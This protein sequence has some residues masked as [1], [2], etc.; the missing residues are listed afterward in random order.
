MS[1]EPAQSEPGST[2]EPKNLRERRQ[3]FVPLARQ[4]A[5]TICG[6]VEPFVS[7][8]RT[9]TK[10]V[11][12]TAQQ[13]DVLVVVVGSHEDPSV[14]DDV[15]A[16]ALAWQRDRDL[17]LVVPAGHEPATLSRLAWID[18]CVRV[19]AYGP[20]L[21]PRPAIILSRQETLD[22]AR[23]LHRDDE[24]NHALGDAET[25][26]S[27]LLDWVRRQPLKEEARANYIA[28]KCD[29]VQV[30][31]ASVRAYH[32]D[33]VVGVDYTGRLPPGTQPAL[34]R[35][36]SAKT[37]LRPE[38]IAE[39]QRRISAAVERRQDPSDVSY[40]EHRLQANL[41]G[42][43]LRDA[44]GLVD[45]QA[46]Y[47]VW[48]SGAHS[49]FIDFLGIDGDGG[50][51]LV[52]TKVNPDDVSVML[53]ALDYAVW[54][55][56]NEEAIRETKGWPRSN[57]EEGITV[58]L[59]CA[60]V[61]KVRP[62]GTVGPSRHAIGRYLAN[63]L[64]VLSKQIKC[65]IWLVSDPLGKPPA[66]R[67][68]WRTPPP[69]NKL[70]GK[71]VQLRRWLPEVNATL[72]K[73]RGQVFASEEDAA[74]PLALARFRSVIERGMQHRWLLS[75]RS[76]QALALNLFA[77]LG[78]DGISII[79]ERFGYL[80]AATEP[81]EFEYS[82]PADRLGERRPD[83]KHQTQVDVLLRGT[84]RRGERLAVLV[85]VKFT[86]E[87]GCCSAYDSKDNDARSNCR[88]AGLYGAEPESCFQLRNHGQGRR[89]YNAFLADQPV[90]LPQGASDDGGCIVRRQLSQPARNLALGQLLVR[91]GEVDRFCYAVCAPES[92]KSAWRR[93]AELRA[94]FPDSGVRQIR[95][96]SV[97]SVRSLHPDNGAAFSEFYRGIV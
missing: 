20:E 21:R 13:G 52:E 19:F 90:V 97:E 85:E 45:L 9:S 17:A 12:Y 51:H 78:T 53:Q 6:V 34:Q 4:L 35:E 86:E 41:A 81:I 2:I 75:V 93:V 73:G 65:R 37:P 29:G 32:V 80:L 87:F 42:R 10:A 11:W 95:T 44:L 66:L 76:S 38:E 39:M 18:G 70:V 3:E 64:E 22:A 59:V 58:H 30:L 60:P 94:A 27:G 36:V 91:S 54:V 71:P 46:E 68:P 92:F 8:P 55:M 61:V 7:T 14:M 31:R 26:L 49:G 79:F 48:R 82:D 57:A 69:S 33:L 83:S 63:Q 15:L 72:T 1:P 89:Q 16:Y 56:A 25:L 40:Q 47:P 84:S 23:E 28:W 67:G 74:L 88:S 43:P 24:R 96:L 77:P 62:D 5:E 50:L